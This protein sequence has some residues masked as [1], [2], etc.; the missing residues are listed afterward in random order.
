[1]LIKRLIVAILLAPLLIGVI[2][3]GG[4]LYY[5]TISTALGVAAWEFWRIFKRGGYAPPLVLLAGGTFFVA[6]ARAFGGFEEGGFV[7]AVIVLLS[8][9]VSV[10]QYERG[11][12]HAAID[13]M[14][15]LG[16]VLY[17]GWLG[18]YLISLRTLPQGMWWLL[19]ILP[20]VWI[21][22]AGAFSIGRR[23]G[24][25][26]LSARVSPHKT[27]EG[28]LGG[29][30]IG[31]AGTVG[32]AALW[33]LNAPDITLTAGLII[34]AAIAIFTPLGDLGE[35]LLK[36]QFS[37]K[38]SSNLLP[39]HGGFLDRIDSWLWAVTIGYYLII[40]VF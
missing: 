33:H 20:S 40:W 6:I 3:V 29:V 21:A 5:L 27:I 11:N 10:F 22:D 16:G 39:G 13:F 12:H 19:L 8:M 28:Y 7:L 30:V 17:I 24:K 26:P 36:R 15:T 9:A 2:V 23:W 25:S 37:V 32:L 4:A 1:M 18:S 31:T 34:G 35:S 14:I 38:D